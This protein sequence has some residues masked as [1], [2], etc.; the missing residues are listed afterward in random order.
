MSNITRATLVIN[1]TYANEYVRAHMT[2][3]KVAHALDAEGVLAPEPTIIR[4]PAELEAQ[5]PDTVVL[6]GIGEVYPVR[7]YLDAD[8]HEKTIYERYL[9]A[10]KVAEGTHLR[11]CREALEGGEG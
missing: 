10:V 4:T 6:D 3:L 5:E 11:A 2:P 7:Y 1:E 8:D 9:P